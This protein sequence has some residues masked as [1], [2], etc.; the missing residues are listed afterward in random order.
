MT[1]RQVADWLIRQQ[2]RLPAPRE[3]YEVAQ[4]STT[5]CKC[6]GVLLVVLIV[7]A[8]SAL[9]VINEIR[10]KGMSLHLKVNAT[11]QV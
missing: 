5:T 10:L 11:Q 1:E 7:L 2:G 9:W 8:G 3:Q 6:V 4:P